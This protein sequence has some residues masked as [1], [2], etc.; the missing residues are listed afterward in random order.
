MVLVA[1]NLRPVITS[2][3][4]VVDGLVATFGLSA[5]AAGALTTV[6]VLC[7]GLFAPLGA[8]VSRRVGES[9]T[10]A[11]AVGLIAAGALLRS[12]AGVAGLYA[13]TAVAGAGIAVAGALLPSVVRARVPA[14]VGPVTGIYTAAL[15]A[16]AFL[17]AG[18]TEPLRDALGVSTQAVLAVWAVPAI[19]AVV[20][21]LAARSPSPPRGGTRVPLPWR[22]GAAWLGAVFMGT[23]SLLFYGSLA[24]LAA[25][26]TRLGMDT[27]H[28][29]LLLALFSATQMVTAFA[30][31]ALAHRFGRRPLWT[32]GSVGVTTVGLF[33]VALAPD[34]F[35]AAPWLWAALLGL[36]MGGNLSLALSIVTDLAPTP[37]EASAYTGM[38]FL[39]GYTLA[40]LG[41]VALGR[42][43]DLTGGYRAGFLV[44]GAVGVVTAVV[45]T[46]AARSTAA[47]M[48]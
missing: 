13:G 8:I 11:L 37:R 44:L 2:V 46:A 7:M 18:A 10:L 1:A 42:L 29:G 35:P 30:L 26:Y 20:V 34:P 15:I 31:P 38:A 43:T 36:G 19:V 47:R 21:W 25:V 32:F 3:P 40:A 23:Q 6:P 22:S 24:W 39:V 48:H 17:A 16:G 27:A 45:G 12:V 4:P 14:R 33:L 9:A 41:P 5:F 28:A